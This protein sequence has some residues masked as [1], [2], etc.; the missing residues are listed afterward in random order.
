MFI[1][2]IFSPLANIAVTPINLGVV[3]IIIGVIIVLLVFD[4]MKKFQAIVKDKNNKRELN[5]KIMTRVVQKLMDRKAKEIAK[6]LYTEKTVFQDFLDIDYLAFLTEVSREKIYS[7]RYSVGKEFEKN[8][9][10]FLYAKLLPEN[11]ERVKQFLK[12][13]L[14]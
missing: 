8:T 9:N 3:L 13:P 2:S 1:G 6:G 7:F 4:K 5:R 14:N 11:E 12:K 10:I